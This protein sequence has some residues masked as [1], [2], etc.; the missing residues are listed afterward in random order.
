MPE[1]VAVELPVGGHPVY[2]DGGRLRHLQGQVLLLHVVEVGDDGDL[3][4]VVVDDAVLV[5]VVGAGAE[6][7]GGRLDADALG[8]LGAAAAAAAAAGVVAPAAL[9]AAAALGWAGALSK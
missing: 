8:G 1:Q 3:A 2:G 6:A 9:A 7:L 5:L 4:V